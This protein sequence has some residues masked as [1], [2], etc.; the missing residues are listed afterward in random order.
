MSFVDNTLA[1][2]LQPLGMQRGDTDACYGHAP[3]RHA[4]VWRAGGS[5]RTSVE[6]RIHDDACESAARRMVRCLS[7]LGPGGRWLARSL[8]CSRRANRAGAWI[9]TEGHGRHTHACTQAAHPQAT[10]RTPP[11]PPSDANTQTH[12]AGNFL[13]RAVARALT[14]CIVIRVPGA[15]PS[16]ACA[17]RPGF[18]CPTPASLVL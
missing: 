2:C 16:L 15:M 5:G 9:R 17:S 11:H 3:T 12:R 6:G 14:A 1:T 10:R 7:H 13:E 8:V 4:A 18:D